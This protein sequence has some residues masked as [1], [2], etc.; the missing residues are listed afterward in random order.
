M[1]SAEISQADQTLII[2]H[3]VFYS[4]AAAILYLI[5]YKT[6]LGCIIPKITSF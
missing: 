5:E 4:F 1:Q 2:I 6:V 3:N